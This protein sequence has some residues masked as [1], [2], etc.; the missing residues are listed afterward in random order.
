MTADKVSFGG[1][2][3]ANRRFAQHPVNVLMDGLG[4]SVTVL[5]YEDR[6]DF[7]LTANRALMPDVCCLADELVE[8]LR[9]VAAEFGIG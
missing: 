3:S 8:E 7:G 6:P 9:T 5:S 1:K 4:L 2:I